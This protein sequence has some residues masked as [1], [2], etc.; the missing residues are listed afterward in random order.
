MTA[1]I[2]AVGHLKARLTPGRK[3]RIQN[4]LHQNHR[5]VKAIAGDVLGRL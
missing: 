1:S 4:P 2:E 5:H 3:F